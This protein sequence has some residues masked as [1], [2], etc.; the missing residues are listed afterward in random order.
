MAWQL[1]SKKTIKIAAISLFALIL[2]GLVVAF[3]VASVQDSNSSKTSSVQ[4]D[5]EALLPQGKTIEDLGGWQKL[6]PPNSAPYYVFADS[7]ESVG[8]SV[9]QQTLPETFKTDTA[10]S[11]RE[12]AKGY[13]ATEELTANEVKAYL[14]TSAKGPQSVIFTKNGLLVLIKSQA[15]IKNDAWVAYIKTLESKN[16]PRF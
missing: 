1:R 16:T 9:S 4:P 11:I 5:F 8:I 3:I 15:N 13:S 12:L 7:I 6:T 14:G 10:Q 2:S